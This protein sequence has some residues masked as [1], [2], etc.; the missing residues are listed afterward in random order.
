MEICEIKTVD[1]STQTGLVTSAEHHISALSQKYASRGL[2][3]A[4]LNDAAEQMRHEE[5]T[6]KLSPDAYRLSLYTDA[7][8]ADNSQKKTYRNGQN[9]HFRASEKIQKIKHLAPP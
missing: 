3:K 2:A 1:A 4:A 5:E 6:R 7:S 9:I 8:T